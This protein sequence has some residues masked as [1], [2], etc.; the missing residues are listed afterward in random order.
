MTTLKLGKRP[1]TKDDR[2]LL[3]RHYT[4]PQLQQAPVGFDHTALVTDPWGM[5]MNDKLGD[6]AIAGPM[7]E[8]MLLNAAAQKQVAFTDADAVAVYSAVTGYVPGEPNTDQGSAVRD[9]LAYRAA[10]GLVDSAGAM[11]KIGAYVA[12]AAGD[13]TELLEALYMFETVGIGIQ[14]PGSAM[15]QFNVGEPWDVPVSAFEGGHYIP[16]VARPDEN[17]AEVITW[18]AKQLMTRA[19]YE[20]CCDEAWCFVSEEDLTSGKTLEGFDLAD[21]AADLDSL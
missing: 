16:V 10:T 4:T 2:D 15:D 14:F 13:W 12:L 5:L 11:H 6:C 9:V 7:H 17:M 19:F 1:A 8:T 20:A 18:G 3:F 21:L